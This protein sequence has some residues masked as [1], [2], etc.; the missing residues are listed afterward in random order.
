M[1]AVSRPGIVRFENHAAVDDAGAFNALGASLFS[2]LWQFEHDR[3]WLDDQLRL[4][5]DHDVDY[6]R[7]LGIVGPKF[8]SDRTVDPRAPG[9]DARVAAFTDHVYDRF[10]LRV[11][12]SI[13]GGVDT[14]PTPESR[15]A[16]SAERLPYETSCA[17]RPRSRSL[18]AR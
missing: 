10:G 7:V 13:F 12:W 17:C 18:G 6:V 4:L 11:E 14:T 8:W 9:Y 5:A 16:A 2:G 15:R 3:G 1:A